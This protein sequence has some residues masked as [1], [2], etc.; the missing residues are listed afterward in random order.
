M[1]EGFYETPIGDL[2]REHF[3]LAYVLFAYGIPYHD[4]AR[5]TLGELCLE[6]DLSVDHLLATYEDILVLPD[7]KGN[8]LDLNQLPLELVLQYLRHNHLMFIQKRMPFLQQLIDRLV[9]SGRQMPGVEDLKSIFPQ[10][11]ES[12]ITHLYEEEDLVFEQV[13]QLL[14]WEKMP[15]NHISQRFMLLNHVSIRDFLDLHLADELADMEQLRRLTKQFTLTEPIQ[16][17]VLMEGLRS[18]EQE[19][20]VHAKIKH[21][22]FYPKALQLEQ[23]MWLQLDIHAPLN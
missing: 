17:H 3:A 14:A 13:L 22:I 8:V 12:F 11:A 16:V 1:R 4:H 9:G 2:L 23:E 7:P 19:L 20:E 15:E 6:K 5:K 10:F 18:F 21:E